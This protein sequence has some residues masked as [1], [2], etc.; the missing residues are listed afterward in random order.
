MRS[1]ALDF[2]PEL[3]SVCTTWVDLSAIR[4]GI[5]WTFNPY[6]RPGFDKCKKNASRSSKCRE[7]HNT[8]IRKEKT[9]VWRTSSAEIESFKP[10]SQHRYIH[11]LYHA[12]E[13]DQ[14]L[15]SGTPL[16]ITQ[17]FRMAD[18]CQNR[19][20]AQWLPSCNS[21]GRVNGHYSI[22][23]LLPDSTNAPITRQE[24]PSEQNHTTHRS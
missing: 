6:L 14:L 2:L 21:L 17:I 12:A 9:Y 19:V 1:H 5:H 7:P 23:T 22:Q 11:N 20:C 16:H 13:N 3:P 24:A 4:W 15:H 18:S 8:V 10:E